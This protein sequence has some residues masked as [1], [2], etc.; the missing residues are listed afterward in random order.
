MKIFNIILLLATLI[1][2]YFNLARTNDGTDITVQ[3]S[4][5][6]YGKTYHS[7]GEVL[8]GSFEIENSGNQN[9]VIHD[10]IP[11]CLCYSS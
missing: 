7:V 11:D 5:I 2:V 9:L 6:R 3:N 1:V 8:S 10:I 4:I